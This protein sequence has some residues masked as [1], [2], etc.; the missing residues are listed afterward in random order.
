MVPRARVIGKRDA[1]AIISLLVSGCGLV[2]G[3]GDDRSLLESGGSGGSPD[4]SGMQTGASGA[5]AT[6]GMTS[7]GVGVGGELPASGASG[8]AGNGGSGG[9]GGEGGEGGVHPLPAAGS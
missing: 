2:A 3:L 7:G 6:G 1:L 4:A 5:V 9:N 8:E